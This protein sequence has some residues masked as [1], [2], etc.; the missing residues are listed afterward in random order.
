MRYGMSRNSCQNSAKTV[1][2]T[3]HEQL[4]VNRVVR[5]S[6]FV[7]NCMDCTEIHSEIYYSSYLDFSANK[8]CTTTL[9]CVPIL[10]EIAAAILLDFCATAST[11]PYGMACSSLLSAAL[12]SVL[13]FALGCVLSF[14]KCCLFSSARPLSCSLLFSQQECLNYPR[15]GAPFCSSRPHEGR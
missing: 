11:N 14:S 13:L 10:S 12:K 5:P 9:E 2:K 15:M 3:Q 8:C 4:L 7:P 1:R 6:K